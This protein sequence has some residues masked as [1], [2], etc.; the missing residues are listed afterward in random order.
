MKGQYEVLVK[1][2]ADLQEEVEKFVDKENSSAGTRLRKGLQEVRKQAQSL[3]IAVSDE[4]AKRKGTP[5][6]PAAAE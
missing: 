5:A 3:R 1:L 4:K 6:T 2:V